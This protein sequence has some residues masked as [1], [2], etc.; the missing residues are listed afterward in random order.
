[1]SSKFR[2]A[3]A[4]T[5]YLNDGDTSVD[6]DAPTHWVICPAC[7]GDGENTW[8]DLEGGEEVVGKGVA[9]VDG[10]QATDI[11]FGAFAV[12]VDVVEWDEHFEGGDVLGALAEGKVEVA[13]SGIRIKN[14]RKP[15]RIKGRFTISRAISERSKSRSNAR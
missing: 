6:L 2:P 15:T 9:G 7:D 12:A 5:V 10:E 13:A 14:P 11:A 1:M 3:I 8:P 4:L